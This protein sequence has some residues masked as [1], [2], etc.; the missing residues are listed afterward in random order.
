MTLEAAELVPIASKPF[1]MNAEPGDDVVIVT[2]TVI[3]DSVRSALFGAAHQLDLD[4][5]LVVIPPRAADNNDP[6]H[7]V[8]EAM[9]SADIYVLAASKALAHSRPSAEAQASGSGMIVMSELSTD[10]LR[11][12]AAT[13]DYSEI[14]RVADRLEPIYADGST[15]RVEDD[16][17]TTLEADIEG[18][19]Y[20]PL[21]GTLFQNATQYVA[22]FPDGE[23]GVAPAEGSTDG[24]IVW[25]QSVHGLGKLDDPIELTVDDGWVTDISGGDDADRFA[26]FLAEKGDDNAYYCAAEIALGINHGAEFTGKLR[27]D[28]KVLGSVHTAVG[29][30]I[31]LGGTIESDLHIDGVT[32]APTVWVDDVK[33]SEGGEILIN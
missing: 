5:S 22:T 15:I 13:A 25:D 4:P 7:V 29:D 3:E 12:G 32:T 33:V 24:T 20:W 26:R 30:N 23:M 17:G 6:P 21:A 11:S 8:G 1:R 10:I 28:K 18:R 16:N 9:Q 27:T 19:N 14:Q 2:D 31:D